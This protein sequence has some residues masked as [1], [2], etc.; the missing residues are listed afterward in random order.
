MYTGKSAVGEFDPA[1]YASALDAFTASVAV[2]DREGRIL[3]VNDAWV[4]FTE[5]NGFKLVDYGVGCDYLAFC[6]R[7]GSPGGDT[8]AA[9]LRALITGVD[10]PFRHEY[11]MPLD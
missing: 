7:L 11:V 1:F 3:S 10:G 6:D 2:L 4:Q 8:V 5:I 9:G